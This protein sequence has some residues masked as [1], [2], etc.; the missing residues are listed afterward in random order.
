MGGTCTYSTDGRKSRSGHH[1]SRAVKH[2]KWNASDTSTSD[3]EVEPSPNVS[4]Y[5]GS[6]ACMETESVRKVEAVCGTHTYTVVGYTLARAMGPGTRLCSDLFEVGGQLFR[7]EVYPAGLDGDARKYVS[8]FLTTPGTTRPG[9]LLWELSILDKSGSKPTHITESRTAHSPSPSQAAA[10]QAPHAG[11]V[12]GFPKFIKA[13]FLHR[14]GHRF[15]P[16]DVLTIRATVRVLTGRSSFPVVSTAQPRL[17]SVHP[18]SGQP[19]A[20]AHMHVLPA[21]TS[22]TTATTADAVASSTGYT[23]PAP[24]RCGCGSGYGCYAGSQVG[25]ALLHPQPQALLAYAPLPPP[26]PQHQQQLGG[27]AGGPFT[28]PASGPSMLLSAQLPYSGVVYPLAMS[29]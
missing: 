5:A 6:G 14:N 15:L 25:G 13:N 27:L 3:S 21:Y 8:L 7:L 22:A 9:H 10:V 26:P 12:A 23:H 11:V 28:A 19:H 17:F 20:H 16:D 24:C 29:G 4:H 2:R 18:S 1:R